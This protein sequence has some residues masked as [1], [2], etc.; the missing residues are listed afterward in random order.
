M[1]V[2][3]A[4]SYDWWTDAICL[5]VGSN[6]SRIGRGTYWQCRKT[7][8]VVEGDTTR[9]TR[10][11]GKSQ[12]MPSTALPPGLPSL[13]QVPMISEIEKALPVIICPTTVHVKGLQ[14][15]VINH[16]QHERLLRE[17]LL[18]RCQ[19]QLRTD[20][21]TVVLVELIPSCHFLY[22]RH[23][24]HIPL[25]HS[26]ERCDSNRRIA[27]EKPDLGS[28]VS[29]S[30][31]YL[32]SLRLHLVT[33]SAPSIKPLSRLWLITSRPDKRSEYIEERL[34][35]ANFEMRGRC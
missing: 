16:Q 1:P 6:P 35:P 8:P 32:P 29:S 19:N 18:P 4:C 33:R 24:S 13:S 5:V 9:S 21:I 23:F 34:L 26:I 12:E 10:R 2:R 30:T 11:L 20:L 28:L 7:K 27:A 22:C 14:S 25:G 31:M 17:V 15:I 3:V